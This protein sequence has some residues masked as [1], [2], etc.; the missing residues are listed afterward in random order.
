M[1]EWAARAEEEA[2]TKVYVEPE[3]DDW[4]DLK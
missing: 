2:E 1:E 4:E 3:P